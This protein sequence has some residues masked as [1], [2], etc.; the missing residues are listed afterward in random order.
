MY[1]R[2]RISMKKLYWLA[3]S[4]FVIIIDQMSKLFIVQDLYLGQSISLTSF[5]NIVYVKN[6]GA[7]FS[8]LDI[9]GGQQRWLFSFISFVISIV[10]LV[11]LFKLKP[12]EK[13]RAASLA[14][15]IGGALANL[16]DRFVLGSVVDF[17]DVHLGVYH[18]PAFNIADSAVT[19][20]AIMLF[21]ELLRKKS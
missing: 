18:W 2:K 1:S 21:I 15:I 20:G 9:P 16:W 12:T 17:L 13:W 14:L 11:W 5:F 7:A 3:L 4:V 10:L 19:I 6:F 8:F